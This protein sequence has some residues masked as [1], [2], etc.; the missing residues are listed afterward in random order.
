[1]KIRLAA[2]LFA[3]SASGALIIGEPRIK[4]PKN[5][6][7]P[8]QDVELGLEA[9]EMV[10]KEI[11]LMTDDAVT[12]FVDDIGKRLVA[13]IP[14]ELQQPEFRYTF[15]TV[16]VSDIN[17]FA[18]PGGPMFVNRGMIEAANS[19]GEVAGVMA[20]E[21]SHVVLRHGTAQAGKAKTAQLLGTVGAVVGA[22][23]GGRVG[24]LAAQGSQFGV[25]AF[26]LRFSRDYEKQADLEGTQIMSTAGYDA[27]DMASLFKTIEKEGSQGPQWL[28]DHPNPGNRADY[29]LKEAEA[30]PPATFRDTGAFERIR[31]RL[32]AMPKAP[33][34]EEAAK[35][36]KGGT[37]PNAPDRAPAGRVPLPST[38]YAQY[39]EGDVFRVS[40]PTNWREIASGNSVTFA[41]DGAVGRSGGQS[42]FTH[43]VQIGVA[44]N[45]NHDLRTATDELVNSLLEDNPRMTRPSIYRSTVVDGV[46]SLQTEVGNAS[47]TGDRE[48]I[49]ITT[50]LLNAKTLFYV[51]AV[52]PERELADYDPAFTRVVNSIRFVR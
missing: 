10:R 27:R 2:L 24:D 35:S 33:T 9:A 43:G 50:A 47:T 46:R 44:S 32:K 13:A 51:I 48:A 5:G 36:R 4:P 20:H 49:R 52:A 16:N 15:E 38:R 39:N 1:M 8:K 7:T 23:I 34:S 19:E 45:E 31:A 6:Y 14:P 17:A 21:I 42:V 37:G 22:I 26:F 41:P 40:V 3:L 18:L 29:I 25:G 28:S 11:P 12:S 30:L